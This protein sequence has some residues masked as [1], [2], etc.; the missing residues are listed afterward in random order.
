M[1]LNNHTQHVILKSDP[2]IFYAFPMNFSSHDNSIRT[3][4]NCLIEVNL[5]I[6]IIFTR[7][8]KLVYLKLIFILIY[9]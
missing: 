9:S 4:S 6:L 2:D 8:F 3:L 7:F 1:L 5:V